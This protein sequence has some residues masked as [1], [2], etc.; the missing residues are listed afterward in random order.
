[1]IQGLEGIFVTATDTGVGKTFVSALLLRV[2]LNLDVK[3]TYFKPVA[4][5]CAV[6]GST[7]VAEDLE[8][9]QKVS[10]A[11]LKD[12]SHCPL[13]FLK[14][15]APL[16][17]SR[18]E[19]KEVKISTI[20]TAFQE[21]RDAYSFVVAEGVGGVLVPLTEN[22]T[23][24]DFVEEARLPSIVIARPGLGTINHTLLTLGALKAREIPVLGF[25]TNGRKDPDDEAAAT[26]PGIIEEFSH[27]PFLGHIPGYDPK[28]HDIDSFIDNEAPF[29]KQLCLNIVGA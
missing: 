6:K 10:G 16:A 8:F 5:G 18:L 7:L 20:M 28:A 3:A 1:M 11:P 29:L 13:K 19:G 23:L 9:V 26:S 24:L 2:L 25:I 27:V 15:L 4:T 22:Y 14:P 21:L 17:A 12:S